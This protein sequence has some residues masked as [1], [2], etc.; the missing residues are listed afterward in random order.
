MHT[1]PN[2][3]EPVFDDKL[4]LIRPIYF[5]FRS[6][7]FFMSI[8]KTPGHSLWVTKVDLRTQCFSTDNCTST[9]VFWVVAPC[10]LVEVYQ[11]FRGPCC[12]H[13]PDDGGSKDFWN[14]GK[15]LPDYS[16]LQPR[17][18]PS[19]YLPPWEPQILLDSTS[20]LPA[21]E[22]EVQTIQQFNRNFS[23]NSIMFKIGPCY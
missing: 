6:T 13:R 16:A 20:V 8:N 11:R 10:S 7:F 22:L 4:E 14:V 9:A 3:L 21:A 15:L 1:I 18:Q 17:R 12:T 2:F 5:N 19:S 23:M